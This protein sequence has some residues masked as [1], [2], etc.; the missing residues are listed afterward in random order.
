M[1][2]YGVRRRSDDQLGARCLPSIVA[3]GGPGALVLTSDH[4]DNGAA[5]SELMEQAVGVAGFD[6]LVLLDPDVALADPSFTAAVSTCLKGADVLTLADAY[7]SLDDA[8]VVLAPDVV[9]DFLAHPA[10]LGHNGFVA[11]LRSWAQRRGYR[12]AT[13]EL[14]IVHHQSSVSTLDRLS[15]ILAASKQGNWADRIQ[16]ALKLHTT[17]PAEAGSTETIDDLEVAGDRPAGETIRPLSGYRQPTR[18]DLLCHLP[19]SARSVLVVGHRPGSC[20]DVIRSATGAAVTE[21]YAPGAPEAP[22][23]TRHDGPVA[24]ADGAPYDAV[25]LAEALGYVRNPG[26]LLRDVRS[27]LNPGGVV[28]AA[29]PNA[30]HWSHVLPL[31]LNDQQRYGESSLLQP[32]SPVRLLTLVEATLLFDAAGLTTYD[33]CNGTRYPG[34][35]PAELDTLLLL[36]QRAGVSVSDARTLLTCFEYVFVVRVGEAT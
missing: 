5:A 6:A 13:A 14:P 1:I 30:K 31:V 33:F 20:A 24:L 7:P 32:D 35:D 2:L 8:L 9:R 10:E 27:V 21:V 12:L 23:G 15:Q 4:A 17:T 25:I 36:Q 22:D 18:P 16:E 34:D 29:I 26:E 28:I 19:Q 11:A 3:C